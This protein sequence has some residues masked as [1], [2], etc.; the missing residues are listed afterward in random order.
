MSYSDLQ[1]IYYFDRQKKQT[2]DAI[3]ML[4]NRGCSVATLKPY[5][6]HV[7]NL[8]RIIIHYGGD[9]NLVKNESRDY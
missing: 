4:S 6:Q 9:C 2:L 5:K 8:N 3:N 1:A 7:K